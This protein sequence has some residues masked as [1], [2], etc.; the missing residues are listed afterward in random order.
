MQ[1]SYYL[2]GLDTELVEWMSRLSFSKIFNNHLRLAGEKKVG[3]P[4]KM[5]LVSQAFALIILRYSFPFLLL[6]VLLSTLWLVVHSFY[7]SRC[8][9]I[10]KKEVDI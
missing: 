8:I 7:Y 9:K 10:H 6:S 1:R 5:Q 2:D 4:P 3:V